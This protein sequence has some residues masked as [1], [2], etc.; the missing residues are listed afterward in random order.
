MLCVTN[1][2]ENATGMK[3]CELGDVKCDVGEY[4]CEPGDFDVIVD[5]SSSPE[6][7]KETDDDT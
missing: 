4:K 6:R 2:S 7:A 3:E 1:D 5:N